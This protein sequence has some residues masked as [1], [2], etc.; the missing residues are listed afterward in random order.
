MSALTIVNSG[1]SLD[2]SFN[3]GEEDTTDSFVCTIKTK[4]FPADSATVDRV[5]PLSTDTNKL[6]QTIKAWTGFLTSTEMTT[7]A[8]VG[9]GTWYLIATLVN[10]VTVENKQIEKRFS[11]ASTW[12][13]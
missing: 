10:S 5:V 6:G 3:I 12:S 7:M 11:I 8:A 1:E 13:D 2:F 4:Q 9:T